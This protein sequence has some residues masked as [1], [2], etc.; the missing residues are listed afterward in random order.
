MYGR[1]LLG[2][3][4]VLKTVPSVKRWLLM[5]RFVSLL[6]AMVASSGVVVTPVQ[7]Q[8]GEP[9]QL[10]RLPVPPAEARALATKLSLR[11]QDVPG[12][13]ISSDARDGE[14]LIM[15]PES[16]QQQILGDA[17]QILS[18]SIQTVSAEGP[19]YTR[20]SYI[21]WRDFEERLG[22]SPAARCR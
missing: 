3:P 7:A 1:A 16:S 13:K 9:A 10:Q 2:R 12:V 22:Q 14:L 6:V 11:Y 19:F 15:A 18:S 21:T 17:R 8:Q 4:V 20:L 5:R